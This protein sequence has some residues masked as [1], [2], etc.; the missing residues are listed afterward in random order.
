MSFL[1]NQDIPVVADNEKIIKKES[2]FLLSDDKLSWE[3]ENGINYKLGVA[4]LELTKP[5]DLSNITTISS[6]QLNLNLMLYSG[7]DEMFQGTYTGVFSL[8]SGL[9]LG[10][11]TNKI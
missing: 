5:I 8:D 3:L 10:N 4:F 1:W 6:L 11:G 7:S 9:I 2:D